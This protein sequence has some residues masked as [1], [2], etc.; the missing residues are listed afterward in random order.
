LSLDQSR[1][2]ISVLI[3]RLAPAEAPAIRT[4]ATAAL[5]RIT[6]RDDDEARRRGGQE[7]WIA[8]FR[9]RALLPENLWLA[10][11]AAGCSARADRLATAQRDVEAQ[12]RAAMEQ[13]YNAS[14]S[15]ARQTM[16]HGMLQE[17]LAAIRQL[18]LDLVER[19]L[20]GS[21]R[22]SPQTS[23]RIIELLADPSAD[24]RGRAALLLDRLRPEGAG[25]PVAEALLREKDPEVAGRLLLAARNWP[26]PV[27]RDVTLRWLAFDDPVI[28]R[29]AARAV[30]ASIEAGV[31][32]RAEDYESI[33]AS[34]RRPAPE[35]LSAEGMK[36]L[37]DLGEPADRETIA[38][39]LES[40]DPGVR[41]LAALA[42]ADRPEHRQR[43]T[44]AAGQD[45]QLLPILVNAIASADPAPTLAEYDAVAAIIAPGPAREDHLAT[46]ASAL[47]MADLLE[48]AVRD[49]RARAEAGATNPDPNPNPNPNPNPDANPAADP[50]T[51]AGEGSSAVTSAAFTERVLARRL[52]H[53][54][55]LNGDSGVEAAAFARA[56]LLLA[57]IRLSMDRPDTALAALEA[58]D[59]QWDADLATEVT[60]ARTVALLLLGRLDD[61]V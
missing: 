58:I 38:A 39:L 31:L 40:P 23:R 6:G 33:V 49:V 25:A 46:I 12:Y 3:D 8:W 41:R 35:T 48:L 26:T 7:A 57:E 36:L 51:G 43:L 37:A 56:L 13:L 60:R 34:L 32:T 10:D 28:R 20:D 45:P 55:S 47:S 24:I 21:H 11:L 22:V 1:D 44:A 27:T 53:A 17:P 5:I 2:T 16:L 30:L 18:G 29:R 9:D 4:A 50:V 54:Q 15:E 19:A 14:D 61:P 42:L 59:P 52:D